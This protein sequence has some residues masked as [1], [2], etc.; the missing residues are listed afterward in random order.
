MKSPRIALFSNFSTHP[1]REDCK[2]KIEADPNFH[3]EFLCT[4]IILWEY[5]QKCSTLIEQQNDIVV[6]LEF[7]TGAIFTLDW[8]PPDFWWMIGGK[9]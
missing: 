1:W 7:F 4:Y 6:K 2:E 9:V 8:F 3:I 5:F